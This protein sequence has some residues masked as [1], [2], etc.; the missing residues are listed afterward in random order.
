MNSSI[1]SKIHPDLIVIDGFD[2][3]IVG[4]AE[5]FGS[6]LFAVYDLNKILAKLESQGMTDDEAMDFYVQNQLGSYLGDRTPAFM[7]PL[8]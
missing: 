8:P 1:I 5:R 3:C 2:D 4:T 7:I 6:E